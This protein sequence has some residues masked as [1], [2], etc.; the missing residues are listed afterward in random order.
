MSTRASR[1]Y[2][3]AEAGGGSSR[4]A[5]LALGI[6]LPLTLRRAIVAGVF[7]V[8]GFVLA[9]T[10]LEDAGEKYEAFLLIIAY[11]IGPWLGVYLTDWYLRRRQ[12]EAVLAG[13][14]FDR[15]HNPWGGFAAMS[16]AMVVSIALFCAQT[17]YTGPVAAAFPGIG[18][19]TFEVGFVLAAGL[20]ALFGA[21]AR[22]QLV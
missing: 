8:I 2:R 6:E 13:L 21:K 11:W 15:T 20:Y 16:I 19:L 7:G 3:A 4:W 10:G 14:L 5:F 22:R 1:T 18:E 17:L 9:L 12:D